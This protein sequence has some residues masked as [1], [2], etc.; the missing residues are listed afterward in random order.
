MAG[1]GRAKNGSERQRA[2]PSLV[3]NAGSGGCLD[4]A[5]PGSAQFDAAARKARV[6]FGRH[7]V[8]LRE[9]RKRHSSNLAA[10]AGISAAFGR[11]IECG[12]SATPLP[13]ALRLVRALDPEPGAAAGMI[14]LSIV[15]CGLG[16]QD[17]DYLLGVLPVLAARE[18]AP[19][20]G[21]PLLLRRDQLTEFGGVLR[22]CLDKIEALLADATA[23]QSAAIASGDLARKRLVAV[24]RLVDLFSGDTREVRLTGVRR[25]LRE[26]HPACVVTNGS[27]RFVWFLVPLPDG[28]TA[29]VALRELCGGK[30]RRCARVSPAAWSRF[31]KIQL[32]EKARSAASAFRIVRLEAARNAWAFEA[33]ASTLRHRMKALYEDFP[34]LEFKVG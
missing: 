9:I 18:C 3:A 21:P 6:V 30:G 31:M 24:D 15:G 33:S 10:A 34:H 25:W 32:G 13:V 27:R 5:R 29:A 11:R 4:G 8:Q 19:L 12:E 1:A 17:R 16:P 7:V 20:A 28:R 2:A 22:T 14:W 26:M 23:S